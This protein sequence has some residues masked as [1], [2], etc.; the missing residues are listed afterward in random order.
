MPSSLVRIFIAVALEE[1]VRR[2]VEAAISRLR[3]LAPGLRWVRPENLHFT[4]AFMGEIPAERVDTVAAAGRAAASG[5]QP[6]VMRLGGLGVFPGR[7]QARV[8]WL[9]LETGQEA[10]SRLQTALAAGLRQ[11]G[12]E[13]EQREFAPHLTL[14]RVPQD[15]KAWNPTAV[16]AQAP[17]L[18]AEQ[19]VN[20][21]HVMRSQLT[22]AGAVYSVLHTCPLGKRNE[23]G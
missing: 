11:A 3:P 12:F 1:A 9:G 5:Q 20:S 16:L 23:A 4:M 22:P 14:A 21:L 15:A 7:G 8:L 2:Q 13:L 19:T 10:L 6:F 18:G 17:A